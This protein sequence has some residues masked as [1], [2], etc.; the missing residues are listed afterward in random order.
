MN[1]CKSNIISNQQYK[2]ISSI[3][4]HIIYET[5]SKQCKPVILQSLITGFEGFYT[6]HLIEIKEISIFTVKL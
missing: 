6:R 5:I 4:Q 2:T 1:S 3:Y